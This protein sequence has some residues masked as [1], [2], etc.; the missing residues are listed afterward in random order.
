[1]DKGDYYNNQ[2][3]N[4]NSNGYSLARCLAIDTKA[5]F[6]FFRR[7]GLTV[8]I[9]LCIFF[10]LA[11]VFMPY[12]SKEYW[13]LTFEFKKSNII[14][15]PNSLLITIYLL[16]LRF[17]LFGSLTFFALINFLPVFKNVNVIITLINGLVFVLPGF[18]QYLHLRSK[19]I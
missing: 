8:R 4:A 18:A 10:C 7:I 5:I 11:Y 9:I 2:S 13:F 12:I 6:A 14:I 19:S 3:W 17:I 1:M 16:V 15:N